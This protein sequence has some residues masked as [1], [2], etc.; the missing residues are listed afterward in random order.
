MGYIERSLLRDEKLIFR[1]T[2]H[3]VTLLRGIFFTVVLVPTL[4]IGAFSVAQAFL[5]PQAV[6]MLVVLFA[7]A[8]G[9]L[10]AIA[11][12]ILK[13]S[14]EFGVTDH[15]VLIKVGFF[16]QRSIELILSKVEGIAVNQTLPGRVLGYGT[17]IV[18]GTGGTKESFDMIQDPFVFRKQVQEQVAEAVKTS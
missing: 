15:R 10:P 16:H 2:V 3:W 8:I 17:I 18:T 12:F 4:A 14:A 7:S 1:T 9:L 5:W 6:Q 11:A 13:A